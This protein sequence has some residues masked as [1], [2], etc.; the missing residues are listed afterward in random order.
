[1]VLL[2]N[3]EFVREADQL[4]PPTVMVKSLDWFVVAVY[5][6]SR[7]CLRGVPLNPGSVH[8]WICPRARVRDE[9]NYLA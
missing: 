9:Q 6:R 1:M 5:D 3:P 4:E 8:P 7:S 2:P